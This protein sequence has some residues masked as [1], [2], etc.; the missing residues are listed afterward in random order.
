MMG[1]ADAVVALYKQLKLLALTLTPGH[2]YDL[3]SDRAGRA[4]ELR[5]ASL[6]VFFLLS[7]LWDAVMFW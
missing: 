4:A 5:V 3:E 2:E 7:V 6:W 1:A